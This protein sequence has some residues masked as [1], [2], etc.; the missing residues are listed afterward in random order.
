MKFETIRSKKK[1][2]LIG[3]ILFCV[4][5][6][7]I[8]ATSLA[9]YKKTTTIK[10]AEGTV[11]YIIPDMK[12]FAIYQ[13]NDNG[14]YDVISNIPI[15][16][17]ILNENISFC[18]KYDENTEQFEKI[19]VEIN[20]DAEV[21]GITIS[22][23]TSLDKGTRCYFY[24]DKYNIVKYILT[25]TT[26][27]FDSI[28]FS[29]TSCTN[30]SYE[31]GNCGEN[32]VGLYCWDT[33]TN[34]SCISSSE[35]KTYFYRGNV[36]NNYVKFAGFYWRIIRI[37]ENGSIRMIYAGDVNIIDNLNNRDE[38]L[39][40]GYDDEA[41]Y[42]ILNTRI[43]FNYAYNDNRYVGFMYDENGILRKS[44]ILNDVLEPWYQTNILDKKLEGYIDKEMGFCGDR[45][46]YTDE[47]G[48]TQGTGVISTYFGSYIRVKTN[49]KP[50]FNCPN[51]EDLYTTSESSIGN[52]SLEYPIGLITADE[53]VF[54]G[55]SSSSVGN[56][57][58][59]LY[60]GQDYWTLSPSYRSYRSPE[61]ARV[62][63]VDYDKGCL[64]SD[65]VN[66]PN[67]AHNNGVRPVINLSATSILSGLGTIESPYI[68]S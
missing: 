51:V 9:A 14:E 63:V 61:C 26:L 24:Y 42:S 23:S 25:N 28:D 34:E 68:V 57:S 35:N 50:I 65:C 20:F 4:S 38:V 2:L 5:V 3:I 45:T 48:I 15:S 1:I 56:K 37:N 62:F 58:F 55:A 43:T 44:A 29:K 12:L 10:I 21:N 16:G 32:T 22:P 17:Y 33:D 41:Q 54:A 67:G 30:G 66:Y 64:F 39:A 13:E 36:K 8:L 49:N 47:R 18:E 46:V 31:G 27:K 7:L 59:Y 19:Q 53:V 60:N 40:N 52:K 6:T 11:N